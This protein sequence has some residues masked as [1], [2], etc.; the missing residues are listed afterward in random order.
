M[1]Q[2][3]LLHHF[4]SKDELLLA[5]VEDRDAVTTVRMQEV[6]ARTG[7]HLREGLLQLAQV[8]KTD[9]VEQ[10]LLTIL[11]AEAIPTDHPLHEYF[12][13]RYSD[14][15]EDLAATLRRAQE[16]NSIRDDVDAD[17][18][19]REIIAT[20]DGLRLQWLLDP[21]RVDLEAAFLAYGDRLERELKPRRRRRV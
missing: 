19:A 10:Q 12:V 1:T 4:A 7:I 5:V 21:Q 9:P 6:E 13:S 17:A 15:R 18:T 8:N 16:E 14:Y 11:S 2:P 3:G 20:C